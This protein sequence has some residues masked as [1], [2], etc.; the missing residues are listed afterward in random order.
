MKPRKS[1]ILVVIAVVLL[2]VFIGSTA[3]IF[4][5]IFF[6]YID[7]EISGPVT[8]NQEWLEL[9]PEE[10]LTGYRDTQTVILYPEGLRWDT[11]NER[12]GLFLRDGPPISVEVE[13]VDRNGGTHRVNATEQATGKG[14]VSTMG[15]Y[16]EEASKGM[17]YKTLRVKSSAP[18]KVK[19]ILWRCYNSGEVLHK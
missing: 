19:K 2:V 3:Y 10:P 4:F 12:T 9:T 18:L 17:V 1:S 13:L 6:P 16:F 5:R 14:D 7:R 15:F 8:L 11:V